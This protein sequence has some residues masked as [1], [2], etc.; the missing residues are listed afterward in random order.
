MKRAALVAA[1]FINI[2]T[3]LNI[4]GLIKAHEIVVHSSI[5]RRDRVKHIVAG[6]AKVEF[7]S[8]P[9]LKIERAGPGA[10]ALS[11]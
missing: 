10:P 7:S 3:S 6:G 8:S 11:I 2:S 4:A 1:L 5:W 9:S